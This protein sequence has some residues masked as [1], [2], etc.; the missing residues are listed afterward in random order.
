MHI[1]PLWL[2]AAWFLIEPRVDALPDGR[3]A[4]RD[5][6]P[7]ASGKWRTSY[8]FD[9]REECE[10]TR[11]RL[12][13]PDVVSAY[14]KGVAAEIMAKSRCVSA[15]EIGARDGEEWDLVNPLPEELSEGRF[16]VRDDKPLGVPNNWFGLLTFRTRQECEAKRSEFVRPDDRTIVTSLETAVE[17]AMHKSRCVRREITP[18]AGD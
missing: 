18:T 11:K 3:H 9:A 15:D 6:E 1:L 7:V 12:M 17:V 16:R 8:P 13:R 5:D 10:A 2:A 4:V 14:S